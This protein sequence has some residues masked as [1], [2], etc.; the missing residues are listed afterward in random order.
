[1]TRGYAVAVTRDGG[2]GSPMQWSLGVLGDLMWLRLP[3]T[4]EAIAKLLVEEIESAVHNERELRP[5][6]AGQ[7]VLDALWWPAIEPAFERFPT[8]RSQLAVQLQV[9]FEAYGADGPNQDAIREAFESYVFGYLGRSPYRE[10][11]AELHPELATLVAR[12][13]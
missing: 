7:F 11:V 6:T 10:I 1:M 3:E 12:E 13:V 4:R 8:D 9:V 5:L 2:T